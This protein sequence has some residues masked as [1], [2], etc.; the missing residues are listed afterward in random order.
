MNSIFVS[1]AG[2]GVFYLALFTV[3][4]WLLGAPCAGWCD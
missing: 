4:A 2:A 3:L 1:I